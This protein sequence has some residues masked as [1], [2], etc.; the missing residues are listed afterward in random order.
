MKTPEISQIP[1]GRT[2]YL[3]Y[4]ESDLGQ[5]FITVIRG[6]IVLGR[7][8][9]EFDGTTKKYKYS[10]KDA[11]G[12]PIFADE[13][14]LSGIKKRFAET[15]KEII[16]P[17]NNIQGEDLHEK[18]SSKV[19]KSETINTRESEVQKIRGQKNNSEKENEINR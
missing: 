5:H 1:V 12:Y 16:A 13:K 15:N 11:A 19:E 3:E 17:E 14:T 6:K 18:T 8:Y 9:R 4:S 10:A 2:K 7:I